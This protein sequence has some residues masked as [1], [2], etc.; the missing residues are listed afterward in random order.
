MIFR[1]KLNKNF[2]MTQMQAIQWAIEELEFPVMSTK[3][4]LRAHYYNVAK[5]LHPDSG[6]DNNKMAK[7]NEAYEILKKYIEQFKFTFSEEEIAK[8]FPQELH[9]NKFRF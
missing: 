1:R 2:K 7:A 5:S 9:V 3:E 4:E 8:Q 6:G